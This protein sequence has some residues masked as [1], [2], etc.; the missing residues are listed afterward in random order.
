MSCMIDER[1]MSIILNKVQGI[2]FIMNNTN[3]PSDINKLYRTISQSRSKSCHLIL[4]Q[5]LNDYGRLFGGQLLSWIDELAGIVGKRHCLSNVTTACVSN[6][7]FI[8]PAF[9]NETVILDGYVTYTGNTSFEV[10]VD[11]YA[12]STDGRQ[13]LINRAYLTLVCLDENEH[14]AKAPRIKIET[15]DEKQK[16]E[17]AKLRAMQRH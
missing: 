2:L 10:E 15:D 14:P 13:R 17:S 5:H 6:A 11:S 9:L 8:A 16:Y 4:Q 3:I 12:E 7:S 1:Q